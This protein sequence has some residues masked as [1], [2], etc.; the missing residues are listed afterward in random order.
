MAMV[1]S[2]RITVWVGIDFKNNKDKALAIHTVRG[3]W[4]PLAA[5]A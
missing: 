5:E 1:E 4:L 2:A 3:V